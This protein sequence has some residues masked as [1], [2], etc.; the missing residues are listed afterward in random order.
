MCLPRRQQFRDVE[1]KGYQQDVS[2]LSDGGRAQCQQ[3]IWFDAEVSVLYTRYLVISYPDVIRRTLAALAGTY[4][5]D[6][7]VQMSSRQI[8]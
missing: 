1:E 2:V 5:T 3:P 4:L 8:F 6:L 7:I